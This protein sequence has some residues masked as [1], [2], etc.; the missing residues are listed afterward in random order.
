MNYVHKTINIKLY[1]DQAEAENTDYCEIYDITDDPSDGTLIAQLRAN[2][3]STDE[4][5]S[6]FSSSYV[7]SCYYLVAEQ[8]TYSFNY[9]IFDQYGNPGT[10]GTFDVEVCLIPQDPVLSFSSYESNI[11]TFE[12]S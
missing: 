4:N 5:P 3:S 12:V 11:L 9:T 7:F 1:I 10:S 8:K 2:V 6:A